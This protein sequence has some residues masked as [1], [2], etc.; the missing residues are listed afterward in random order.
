MQIAK[1]QELYSDPR[2]AKSEVA[3]KI[4]EVKL[5]LQYMVFIK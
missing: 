2:S 1:L 4:N 5:E 3:K